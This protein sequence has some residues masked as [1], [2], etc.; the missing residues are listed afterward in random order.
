MEFMKPVTKVRIILVKEDGTEIT[1]PPTAGITSLSFAPTTG[2]RIVQKGT[3]HVSYPMQ[4][5]ITFSQYYPRLNVVGSTEGSIVINDYSAKVDDANPGYQKWYYVLPHIEQEAFQLTL[6]A[7]NE[8]KMAT[9]P[10]EMMRWN[11]NMEYT[12]K[13]K[14]T[15]SNLQF[16]DIV[17]I[18][19]K[20]WQ[21]QDIQHDIYNW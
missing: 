15:A 5:V 21:M 18:G 20:E 2:E 19:V 4:G 6:K 3:L 1:D 8:T 11:P 17:Q 16:I 7:N 10:R 13:F 12:Y 9:V 14:L